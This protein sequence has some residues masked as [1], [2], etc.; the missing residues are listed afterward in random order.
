[1]TFQ[2]QLGLA[3]VVAI[4]APAAHGAEPEPTTQAPVVVKVSDGFHWLDACI[5]A[6]AALAA[7]LLVIG[8]TLSVRQTN[9]RRRET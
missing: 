3:L 9:G 1:M 7:V 8:L 2:R 6:A 5:G 4:V